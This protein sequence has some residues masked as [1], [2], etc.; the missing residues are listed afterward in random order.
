MSRLNFSSNLRQKLITTR[1]LLDRWVEEHKAEADAA[2]SC[3]RDEMA[4][5]EARFDQAVSNLKS[6]CISEGLSANDTNVS[7]HHRELD[8]EV[9]NLET[10]INQLNSEVSSRS[11]AVT[12]EYSE[13]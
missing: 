2:A 3:Q 12:G 4:E 8:E 13:F 7:I 9:E 6:L 5:K 10:H 1:D 11:Q